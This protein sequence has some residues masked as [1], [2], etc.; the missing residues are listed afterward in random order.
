MLIGLLSSS[1]A[2]EDG[3]GPSYVSLLWPAFIHDVSPEWPNGVYSGPQS[4]LSMD[5][6]LCF[7]ERP[8]A[9]HVEV[10]PQTGQLRTTFTQWED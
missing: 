1:F 4:L 7:I 9:V 8:E 3:L 2:H 6:R 10:D 5:R